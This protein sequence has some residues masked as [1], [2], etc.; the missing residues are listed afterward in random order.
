MNSTPFQRIL[1]ANRGEIACRVVRAAR[2]R[3][4]QSVAAYSEADA[5]AL[6]VRLADM[7]VPIGPALVAQSYLSIDA[8]LAA[9]R[10]SG[11]A[12]NGRSRT[13]GSS[14]TASAPSTRRRDIRTTRARGC[15][16]T[17]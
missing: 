3:G 5:G 15:G 6:H 2:G 9:A 16:T 14:A 12:M 1:I 17:A 7:A 4:L 11:A 10:A 13:R 8:I